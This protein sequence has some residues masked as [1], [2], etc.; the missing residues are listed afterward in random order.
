MPLGHSSSSY[1]SL[2]HFFMKLAFAAPASGEP[3]FSTALGSQASRVH[4]VM[5]PLVF[6]DP[7][8]SREDSTAGAAAD[9]AAD[10]RAD[11]KSASRCAAAK[12]RGEQLQ[13]AG[14]QRPARIVVSKPFLN[15]GVELVFG[16][17]GG[18]FE[19]HQKPGPWMATRA[20]TWRL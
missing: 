1:A 19:D 10:E 3:F 15:P 13:I 8:N 6:D 7:D 20:P 14:N 12:D 18:A 9:N 16:P 11:I 17:M 2:S 4:F 5:K